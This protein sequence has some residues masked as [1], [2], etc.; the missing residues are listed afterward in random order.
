MALTIPPEASASFAPQSAPDNIDFAALVAAAGWSGVVSGCAVTPQSTPNMTVQVASGVVAIGG[1]TVAVSAV[2]SLTIG[3]ASAADRRDIV[4]VN[5]SG[6][7]SVVAGTTAGAVNGVTSSGHDPGKPAIPASSVILA[8]VYVAANTT[9]IAA[10][11]I[12]DK[13]LPVPTTAPAGL[14]IPSGQP[15]TVGSRSLFTGQRS[16]TTNASDT[17]DL[18][19]FADSTN[20][21]NLRI[22]AHLIAG[23]GVTASVCKVWEIATTQQMGTSLTWYLCLPVDASANAASTN[24]FA[25]EV[26]RQGVADFFFR[27]RQKSIG[28]SGTIIFE[29]EV[30]GDGPVTFTP[31]TTVT[32]A[33]AAVA[34]LHPSNVLVSAA[35]NVGIGTDAP[36]SLLTVIGTVTAA[37]VVVGAASVGRGVLAEAHLT[38]NGTQNVVTTTATTVVGTVSTNN[39]TGA[40][41]ANLAVTVPVVSGRT[42]LILAPIHIFSSV[43]GDQVQGLVIASTGALSAYTPQ[44]AIATGGRAIPAVVIGWYYAAASG[45]VTFT[46]QIARASGTGNVNAALG[47]SIAVLDVG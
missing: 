21:M 8:E 5:S 35:G 11:N 26:Q 1:V 2:S 47:S 41:G 38:A 3:A 19:S 13:S 18:G 6:V 34:T 29:V 9:S 40:A 17:V 10:T 43:T 42:Y 46:A 45:S 24:D 39:G 4:V 33:P 15:F 14:T 28:A 20:T 25:L 16:T 30:I 31:S 32:A 27:F 36:T 44:L 12:I 7:V 37:D 22:T 23:L